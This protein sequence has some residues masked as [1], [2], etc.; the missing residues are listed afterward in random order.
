MGT[1]GALKPEDPRQVGRYQIVARLGVGGMGR[2]Y[3]AR[4]PGGRF[5]AVKV[6]C[7]ELADDDDFR[8]RFAR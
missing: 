2:V 8:R 4:S 5:L 1:L 6:V 3:L 7:P